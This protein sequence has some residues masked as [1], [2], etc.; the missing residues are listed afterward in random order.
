MLSVI[1]SSGYLQT[2]R[3]MCVKTYVS[4]KQWNYEKFCQNHIKNAYVFINEK[5]PVKTYSLT[6]SYKFQPSSH[7]QIHVWLSIH[8][9]FTFFSMKWIYSINKFIKNVW[10]NRLSKVQNR[11]KNLNVKTYLTLFCSSQYLQKC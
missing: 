5:I 6:P 4:L 9:L 2:D 10:S 11:F 3:I 8:K 7:F 1:S